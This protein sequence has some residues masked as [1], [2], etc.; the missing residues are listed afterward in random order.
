MS[1]TKDKLFKY[2]EELERQQRQEEDRLMAQFQEERVLEAENMKKE[3]ENEWE[4]QLKELTAVYEGNQKAVKK[5]KTIRE[6]CCCCL[7]FFC[8]LL[9]FVCDW[10]NTLSWI[11]QELYYVWFFG[12]QAH[13]HEC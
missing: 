8:L 2:Q 5:D 13:I 6:V 1:K 11:L 7:L 9:L 10:R 4:I 12:M 3:F